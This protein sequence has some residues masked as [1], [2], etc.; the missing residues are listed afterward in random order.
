VL[1]ILLVVQLIYATTTLILANTEHL[2]FRTSNIGLGIIT[3]FSC[4]N[5]LIISEKTILHSQGLSIAL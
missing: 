2:I 1:F 3:V 5:T 4:Y